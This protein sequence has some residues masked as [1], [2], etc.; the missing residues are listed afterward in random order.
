LSA[1]DKQ[2]LYDWVVSEDFLTKVAAVFASTDFLVP[3]VTVDFVFQA[4]V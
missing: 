4:A 3:T 1:E 2:L